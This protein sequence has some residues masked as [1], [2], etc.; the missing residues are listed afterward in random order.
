M[1]VETLSGIGLDD[2]GSGEPALLGLP[3][4]CG[5]RTAFDPLLPRFAAHRRALALDLPDQGG[6]T[7]DV[8]AHP[9]RDVD[10]AAVVELAVTALERAGVERVVPVA[11]AHAGWAA[12]ELRRRLG[13]D[14]VPGIVLL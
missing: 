14:R 12:I 5:E 3:G 10:T 11:M 9:G 1:T 2:L 13:A 8:G 7:W 4:W 6:S